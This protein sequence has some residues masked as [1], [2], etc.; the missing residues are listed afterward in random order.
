MF[1]EC[2]GAGV[3][4]REYVRENGICVCVVVVWSGVK[5]CEW[6]NGVWW[7]AVR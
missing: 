1:C 7:V 6:W 2:A 5:P 4:G 3:G